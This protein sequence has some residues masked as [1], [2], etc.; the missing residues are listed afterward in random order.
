MTTLAA[1][2]TSLISVFVLLLLI[3]AYSWTKNYWSDPNT[4]AWIAILII[5][6]TIAV[7]LWKLRNLPP[8]L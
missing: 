4:W 1:I 7:I 5:C 6:I 2:L 3:A 8:P